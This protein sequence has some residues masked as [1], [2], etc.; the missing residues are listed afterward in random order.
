MRKLIHGD[1]AG[2]RERRAGGPASITAAASAAQTF[3]QPY[4]NTY[5]RNYDVLACGVL[6]H[7]HAL[8]QDSASATRSCCATNRSATTIYHVSYRFNNGVPNQITERTTPYQKSQRQPAA[9]GLYAQDSG[10]A[11]LTLNAGLRSTI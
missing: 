3:T 9:I 4:Q 7:W 8:V 5:G 6:R 11:Q 10:H 2:I 1:R